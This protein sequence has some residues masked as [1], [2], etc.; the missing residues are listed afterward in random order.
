MSYLENTKRENT[1]VRL[2]FLGPRQMYFL[3][4]TGI[5]FFLSLKLT[6]IAITLM[7]SKIL[8]IMLMKILLL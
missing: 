5:F 6:R 8:L 2:R 7:C 4:I 1:A 3:L